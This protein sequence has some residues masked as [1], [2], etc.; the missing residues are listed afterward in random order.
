MAEEGQYLNI[1]HYTI[2]WKICKHIIDYIKNAQQ[3]SRK[4]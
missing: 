4:K 2:S 3:N 1:I